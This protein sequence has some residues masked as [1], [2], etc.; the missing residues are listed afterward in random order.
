MTQLTVDCLSDIFEYLE[1][2]KET[3]Y[4]CLLANRLWCESRALLHENGISI[5]TPTL[6]PP[7]FN[8]LSFC[9]VLSI[10][11][12]DHIILFSIKPPQRILA[13]QE[14]LKMIVRISSLK[15]LDCI[16]T[17]DIRVDLSH[18]SRVIDC[19]KD[20]SLLKI[21][22]NLD[23]KLFYILSQNCQNIKSFAIQFKSCVLR[24]LTDLIFSQNNLMHLSLMRLNSI[25]SLSSL[26]TKTFRH[27]NQVRN[28]WKPRILGQISR[29]NGKNLRELYTD[30]DSLN[31]ASAKFCLNLFSLLTA[32]FVNTE[33]L[34][35]I[36]DNCRQLESIQVFYH[37]GKE[38]LEVVT[39]YSQKN[40]MN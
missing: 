13:I 34:K 18:L 5:T 14:I 16:V 11:T 15:K 35:L 29:N 22:S 2:D 26:I 9:K 6:N 8:Y 7:L 1:N 30:D 33:E 27:L 19:L 20:L 4:S 24:G 36:L 3:L 17:V 25:S 23:F 39:K 12:I 37:V 28:L 21:N 10:C 32:K 40:F 31:L 38:S